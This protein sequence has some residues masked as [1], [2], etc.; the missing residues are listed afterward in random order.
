LS[1]ESRFVLVLMALPNDRISQ[2]FGGI[3]VPL[4]GFFILP[5]TTLMYTLV[6]PGGL[7][8]IDI[9]ILVIAVAADIGAWGGGAR[10]R[11]RRS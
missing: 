9:V 1:S 2:A 4:I 8:V 5:W 6:A 3:I 11:S 10:E 7:G